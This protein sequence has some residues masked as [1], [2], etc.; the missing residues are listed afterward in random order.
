MLATQTFGTTKLVGM[1]EGIADPRTRPRLVAWLRWHQ[2]RLGVNRKELAQLLGCSP[3]TV[4]NL[5]N[6]ITPPGLDT[7][8]RMSRA[9]HFPVEQLLE[10]D[11]PA[12]ADAAGRK[13]R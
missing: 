8:V 4:S 3:A 5:L 12:A 11:P 13:A 6:E 2:R 1:S 10:R 9:L 7:L